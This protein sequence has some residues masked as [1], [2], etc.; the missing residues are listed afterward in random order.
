MSTTNI[1]TKGRKSAHLQRIIQKTPQ[2][3]H[4]DIPRD[5]TTPKPKHHLEPRKTH[6]FHA[7]QIQRRPSRWIRQSRPPPS[8]GDRRYP[9]PK[10]R[11]ANHTFLV[12]EHLE[13]E[14]SWTTHPPHG[15]SKP[16]L[17]HRNSNEAVFCSRDLFNDSIEPRKG[18]RISEPDALIDLHLP[19]WKRS[20][21]LRADP[22]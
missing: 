21:R 7:E 1:S 18:S 17:T 3:F 16:M 19:A 10:T 12:R 2:R 9:D 14:S 11:L 20:A 6:R 22:P 5:R 15:S 4:R 13:P 8:P